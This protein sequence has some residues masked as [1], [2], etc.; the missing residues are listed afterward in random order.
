MQPSKDSL[1]LIVQDSFFT[2][3]SRA[4]AGMTEHLGAGQ[5]SLFQCG[6]SAC[7]VQVFSQ[8][9]RVVRLPT[10]QLASP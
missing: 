8:H 9:G 1:G 4:S 2:H 7:L 6:L 5:A 10:R 3:M